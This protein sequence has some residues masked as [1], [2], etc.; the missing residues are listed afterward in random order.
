[1]H[2]SLLRNGR[3]VLAFP[4]AS[5]LTGRGRFAASVKW[6]GEDGTGITIPTADGDP[7]DIA[8]WTVE[9]KLVDHIKIF[10]AYYFMLPS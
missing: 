2:P 6:T 4:R 5:G 8:F 7:S 1:M 9:V 3:R 10:V